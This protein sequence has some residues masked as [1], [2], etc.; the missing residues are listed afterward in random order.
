MTCEADDIRQISD[1]DREQNP[2]LLDRI[3]TPCN[4][5]RL[6]ENEDQFTHPCIL[7]PL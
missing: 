3:T 2:T 5:W 6:R 7:A 4:P 1:F